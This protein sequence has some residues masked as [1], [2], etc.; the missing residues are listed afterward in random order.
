MLVLIFLIDKI[1]NAPSP[2]HESVYICLICSSK[3][4][5]SLGE[6]NSLQHRKLSCLILQKQR[7]IAENK[8]EHNPFTHWNKKP[9][10]IWVLSLTGRRVLL[11][12]ST[13]S[14]DSA[15]VTGAYWFQLWLAA[16]ETWHA[17]GHANVCCICWES[18]HTPCLLTEASGTDKRSDNDE[19]RQFHFT[20]LRN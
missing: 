4:T 14:N 12:F 5:A 17:G 11:P 8:Q 7:T 16:M 9:A 18:A 15:G 2:G 10:N 6:E 13:G 3:C 19:T 1:Q 20:R